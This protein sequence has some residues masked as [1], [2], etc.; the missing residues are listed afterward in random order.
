MNERGYAVGTSD[1]YDDAVF[2]LW[3]QQWPRL[4]RSFSFQTAGR[5]SKGQKSAKF[6]LRI[7]SDFN[8]VQ[9]RAGKEESWML[10]ALED[11]TAPVATGFRTFLWRYGSDIRRGRERFRELAELY[12]ALKASPLAGE[13]LVAVFSKVIET[14]PDAED[15]ATLKADLVSAGRAPY[16]TLPAADP[17]DTIGFFVDHFDGGLPFPSDDLLSFGRDVWNA[18]K[19]RIIE[20]AERA[21]EKTP[22][23]ER[24]LERCSTFVT[25]DEFLNLTRDKPSFRRRMVSVNPLLLDSDETSSL[26]DG[27]MLDL[28]EAALQTGTDDKKLFSRLSRLDNAAVAQLLFLKSPTL[29]LEYAV[30][31]IA[32]TSSRAWI[33]I[34]RQNSEQVFELGLVR[35]VTST[36]DLAKLAQAL[37]FDRRDVLKHG[38]AQWMTALRGAVD[39]VLGQERERLLAFLFVIFSHDPIVGSETVFRLCFETLHQGMRVSSLSNE[40]EAIVLRHLPPVVWWR[41]WDNCYRLKLAIL[42]A[43][44]RGNLDATSLLNLTKDAQLNQ[45]MYEALQQI[46]SSY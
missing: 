34:I 2:S 18:R 42:N 7:T 14:F 16:S 6:D 21:P 19:D 40:A 46:P 15:A 23:G 22:L 24:L 45:E 8:L 29:S 43:Y 39:D 12:I 9:P 38:S 13:N 4:R 20:L 36:K 35:S 30:R 28:V 31:N 37:G 33:E 17:I 1:E 44:A 3:S 41:L 5:V 27:E 10:P 25:P 32:V 26:P 11:L